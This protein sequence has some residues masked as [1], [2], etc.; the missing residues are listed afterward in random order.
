LNPSSPYSAAKAGSDLLVRSYFVTYKMPVLITRA[1][2]NYGPHQFPEKL[3]PLMIANALEEKPLPAAQQ[4]DR[5]D[6][7]RGWRG[8]IL[9]RT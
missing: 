9:H 6:R 7:V 5:R 4:S 3:I 2:N 1:S 8:C